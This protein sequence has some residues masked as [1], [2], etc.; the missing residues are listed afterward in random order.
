MSGPRVVVADD[1][2]DILRLIERRLSRRGY[3]VVTASNGA[4]ALAAVA[5]GAP[6]A[7]VI[8]W[9]MPSMSGSQVCEALKSDPGTASIPII[10]LTAK[11]ADADLAEGLASGADAYLTKPFEINELDA[12]VRSV[13]GESEPPH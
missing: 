2:A 11:A 4:E 6:Q 8:D 5:A 9:L 13:I 1:D 10:L 7:V 12:L 3:D